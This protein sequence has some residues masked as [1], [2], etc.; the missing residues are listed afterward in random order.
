MKAC[1]RQSDKMYSKNGTSQSNDRQDYSFHFYWIK[2]CLET[3]GKNNLLQDLLHM[4]TE[5]FTQISM[6]W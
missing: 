1:N 2:N 4:N 5:H 6:C 3:S